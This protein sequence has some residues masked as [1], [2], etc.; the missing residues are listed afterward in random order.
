[1]T[2][3]SSLIGFSRATKRRR[4]SSGARRSR[5]ASA[6]VGEAPAHDLVHAAADERVDGAAAQA[7][8]GRS[9]ARRCRAAWAAWPGS[10]SRPSM[11]AT[12]SMRSASRVTSLRRKAGTSTSRPPGASSTPKPR[13]AQ[14]LGL[15]RARDRQAEDL[16]DPVLAQADD[17][18]GR[19]VAADVDRPGHE[20]RARQL[21]HEPR[22]D[23]LGLHRLLG[24]QALLEAPAGLAAQPQDLRGAVDV[25]AVPVGDLHE[26]ARRALVDLGALA[27]HDAGDR[28]RPVGVVDDEHLGRRGC[29]PARRA[30]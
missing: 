23:D 19:A 29:A 21:E 17:D 24:R 8:L 11:R 6:G 16:L 1:M 22:G 20:A 2:V 27:A 25:G 14:D 3:W 9:A 18:A 15:A 10:F 4:G 26:H 13:R 5:S 12:S 28:G 30:W 7:L